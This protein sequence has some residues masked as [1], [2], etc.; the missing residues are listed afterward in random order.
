MTAL[1]TPNQLANLS[2]YTPQRIRQLQGD[3]VLPR[4]SARGKLPRDKA[5]AAL[6]AHLRQKVEKYSESR[7]AAL[8]NEQYCRAQLMEVKLHEK[9]GNL[10]PW[11]EIK[12]WISD[13]AVRIREALLNSRE[14]GSYGRKAAQIM[15]DAAGES[16]GKDKGPLAI[17]PRCLK[18]IWE[19]LS[20]RDLD[21]V[22]EKLDVIRK[23]KK[24]Y[25]KHKA[26]ERS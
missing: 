16:F 19:D 11:P 12:F 4:S 15:H 26:K 9:L 5:I 21:K 3:G 13:L 10:K 25:E 20:H 7:S 17:C 8:N 2:G 6:F 24:T 22:K 1:I 23:V 18:P 14:L